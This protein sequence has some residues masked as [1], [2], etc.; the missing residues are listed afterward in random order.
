MADPEIRKRGGPSLKKEGGGYL[1][2]SKKI[3]VF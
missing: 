1:K 3:K 2:N